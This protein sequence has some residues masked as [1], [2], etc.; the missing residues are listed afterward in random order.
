MTLFAR[1][2][3][4]SPKLIRFGLVGA[5]GAIINFVV[6][7]ILVSFVHFSVN[8]GAIMAFFFAVTHN[9]VLNHVWTFDEE[10]QQKPINT[11]QYIYYFAGNIFGLLINLLVLNLVVSTMGKQMYLLGQLFGIACGML[12]NFFLQKN[13]FLLSPEKVKYAK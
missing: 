5:I 9:Y 13:S 2:K 10:N 1:I 7:Y 4:N 3:R 12:S 11:Q 6:Y 8:A